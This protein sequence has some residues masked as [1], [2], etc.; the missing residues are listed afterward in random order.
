MAAG[1]QHDKSLHVVIYNKG[2][3]VLGLYVGFGRIISTLLNHYLITSDTAGKD[4][5]IYSMEGSWSVFRNG[6]PPV[7]CTG[8]PDHQL[9]ALF[10][11]LTFLLI[12]IKV[13]CYMMPFEL[14]NNFQRLEEP[15]CPILE[16]LHLLIIFRP[17]R[18]R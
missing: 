11:V 1:R 15:G 17:W 6:G 13:F 7:T 9:S 10:Q 16:D 14:A 2:N 5:N 3:I 12:E 18:W 8:F 4:K